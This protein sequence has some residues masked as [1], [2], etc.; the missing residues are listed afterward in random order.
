MPWRAVWVAAADVRA[1]PLHVTRNEQNEAGTRYGTQS[2]RTTLDD[3]RRM[4]QLNMEAEQMTRG[5]MQHDSESEDEC[6]LWTTRGTSRSTKKLVSGININ[7]TDEVKRQLIW[8]HQKVRYG[9]RSQV[10]CF[11]DLDFYLLV[12]SEIECLLGKNMSEIERKGRL[13]LLKTSAYH[14]KVQPWHKI[15]E[16][17]S[18]IMIDV[19]KDE[20]QWGESLLAVETSIFFNKPSTE[21]VDDKISRG[22]NFASGFSNQFNKPRTNNQGNSG[23]SGTGNGSSRKWFCK[24]FQQGKCTHQGAHRA[25]IGDRTVWVQHFCSSCYFNGGRIQ[26]HPQNSPECPTSKK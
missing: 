4:E 18:T 20:R 6:P 24:Y 16:F 3:L 21:K 23:G 5:R 15:Q 22:K 1:I 26:N 12:A 17:Y 19:E 2:Q 25:T 11:Q 10:N 7:C 13:E 9:F 14:A 8:P